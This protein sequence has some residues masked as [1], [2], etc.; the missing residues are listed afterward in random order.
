[1][2]Q[3]AEDKNPSFDHGTHE[4]FVD[5]Y[6][7]KSISDQS[8]RRM[9]GIIDCIMR[10]KKK[11]G[12]YGPFCVADIGCGAG[13]MSMMW[14][15][16]HHQVHALDVNAKLIEIAKGRA[17]QEDLDV[18]FRLGSATELP[19]ASDS[20]DICIAPELLEHVED[21]RACL[22]EFIR[23]LK[24]GGVLFITTS[25]RLCPKQE[26]FS[27]PFYSWY[28]KS[29]KQHYVNVARTS[30]PEIAGHAKYPAVNWFSFYQL[31][32]V[33]REMGLVSYDRFDVMDIESKRAYQKIILMLLMKSSILRWLGHVATPGLLI[34]AEKRG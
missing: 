15:R 33:L 22:T 14:A 6:A 18:D 31:R 17:R 29:L 34:L 9:Q 26:E 2:N 23:I 5:Y 8:T 21:W 19:W 24:P 20:M 12:D 13:T 27:L 28:P 32:D 3:S 7:E 25:N 16:V 1:M 10:H 11:R 4:E 30:R